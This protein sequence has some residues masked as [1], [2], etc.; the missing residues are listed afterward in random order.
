[1]LHSIWPTVRLEQ[2]LE[3]LQPGFARDPGDGD[4]GLPQLRTNNVNRHGELDLSSIKRVP[5]SPSEAEKYR[6]RSGDVP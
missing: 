2:V 4:E 6:V 5:T 3:S 1:M